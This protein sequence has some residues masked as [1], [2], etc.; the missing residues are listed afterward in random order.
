M[1][2]PLGR[3]LTVPEAA[4]RLTLQVDTIRKWILFR[5]IGVVRLGRAV[6]IPESEVLAIL[7][8]GYSPRE[9]RPR[10]IRRHRRPRLRPAP[11]VETA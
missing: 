3:L 11:A 1:T 4:A 6:R 9:G 10:P 5:R 8:A 7:T 2:E